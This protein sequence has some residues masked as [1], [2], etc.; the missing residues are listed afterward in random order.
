MTIQ[1]T[2]TRIL[3]EILDLSEDRIRPET[4]LIRDLGAESIDLLEI[5]VAMQ[6]HLHIPVDDDTLFLK[7]AR[8]VLARAR[9]QGQE[10]ATALA[11][12]YPHLGS[13]R[14]VQI[15]KDLDAGPVL[16]VADLLAYAEAQVRDLEK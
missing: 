16:R 4:Y 1:A 8:T 3:V 2:I 7:N 10:P 12:A 15:L 13:E 9:Q 5:G 11:A 6:H 14:L